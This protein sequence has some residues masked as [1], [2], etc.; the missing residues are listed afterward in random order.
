MIDYE[1]KWIKICNI[2]ENEL[3]FTQEF[4]EATKELGGTRRK[5]ASHIVG[6]LEKSFETLLDYFG[7]DDMENDFYDGIDGHA[8]DV[9]EMIPDT[10]SYQG[11]PL[12]GFES[13]WYRDL[14]RAKLATI[15]L[16][17]HII[18][19]YVKLWKEKVLNA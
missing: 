2:V 15:S 6:G 18:E 9:N 19:E 4:M 1:E 13:D 17:K 8:M 7:P 5:F 14:M 16:P 12:D 3:C 10:L 11:L